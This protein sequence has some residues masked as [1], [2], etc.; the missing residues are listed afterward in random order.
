MF[1]PF[2][3]IISL[4]FNLTLLTTHVFVKRSCTT[5]SYRYKKILTFTDKDRYIQMKIMKS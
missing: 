4:F 5:N 3:I 2:V 1:C